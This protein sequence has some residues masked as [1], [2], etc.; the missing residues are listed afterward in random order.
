M[1]DWE[2]FGL[3]WRSSW[4]TETRSVLAGPAMDPSLMLKM[5]VL[6]DLH[7]LSGEETELQVLDCTSF[8]RFLGLSVSE[9][10]PNHASDG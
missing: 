3:F 5:C 2:I 1:K 10:G 8:R 9:K 4:N 7:G 6:Q